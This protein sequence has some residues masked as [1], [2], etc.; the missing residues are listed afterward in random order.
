MVNY[1]EAYH[2]VE[3]IQIPTSYTNS[4]SIIREFT[5]PAGYV[6]LLSNSTYNPNMSVQSNCIH[7]YC[8][9]DKYGRMFLHEI[10]QMPE[11]SP[12]ISLT[13]NKPALKTKNYY[14]I[15]VD[16][17]IAC[18]CKTWPSFAKEWISRDRFLGWPTNSMIQQMSSLGFFVV[19]K[20]HPLSPEKDIEWRASFSLQERELM[21]NLTDVQHKCYTLLKIFNQE[22]IKSNCITSY[23]WKTCLFYVIEQ[24]SEIIWKKENLFVC[25]H[26]C[27]L[28]MLT[29]VKNEFCPNYFIPKDNLFAGTLNESQKCILAGKLVDLLK[30][31]FNSLLKV[32]VGKMCDYY[33]TRESLEDFEL[34]QSNSEYDLKKALFKIWRGKIIIT[35]DRFNKRMLDRYYYDANENVLQ[36]IQNLWNKLQRIIDTDTITE[37]TTSE[38][39]H[40]ISSL[41]PHIYTCLASNIAAVAINQTNLKV[42][43]F[44]LFGSF[45]Y[46]MKGAVSGTLKWI[47]V[48]YAIGLYEDCEWYISRLDEEYIKNAPSVC[49]CRAV[50]D[51][52]LQ[53]MNNITTQS[54]V[55]TCVSFLSSE[56]LITPNALKYEMFRY[57]GITLTKEDRDHPSCQWHYRTVVDCNVYFFFLKFLI[58]LELRRVD[59]YEKLKHI[60]AELDSLLLTQQVRH[61]DVY[62]NLHA[63]MV[64]YNDDPSPPT[65]FM[66]LTYSWDF[67]KSLDLCNSIKS[68]E[69]KQK[70]Y[71]FNA[72]KL[73]ALVVL[74]NTWFYKKSLRVKWCF[75]C[76]KIHEQYLNR[77]SRC[78]ISAY[79]DTNCQKQNRKIHK[80]VCNIVKT[81]HNI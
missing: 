6:K 29:W 12:F 52:V 80:A 54:K 64:T 7:K 69:M 43:D 33:R 47:S 31:G 15:S 65:A 19:K 48:L 59:M 76:Y 24:N 81:Y 26:I 49:A 36:F 21:F 73:H 39:Q 57:F 16:N 58:Q 40:A 13:K 77:C 1:K 71:Q 23:H 60:L 66:F 17:N 68:K 20:G 8:K 78:K 67:M 3:D 14:G 53:D 70:Q 41:L 56:L 28:Q 46:F 4:F 51:N 34:L 37:H 2:V 62:F 45:T 79:C 50:N 11:E 9:I 42:R 38:T 18:L 32:K 35:L 25:I 63:W 72:A 61:C 75:H 22:I 30:D 27:I 55:S 5:T 10:V 74:Y 44:L